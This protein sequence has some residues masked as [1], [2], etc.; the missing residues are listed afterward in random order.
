MENRKDFIF[1]SFQVLFAH[2]VFLV[3]ICEALWFCIRPVEGDF[4]FWQYCGS[5]VVTLVPLGSST[6][7]P[8]SANSDDSDNSAYPSPFTPGW[9]SF[10]VY[11]ESPFFFSFLS[12]LPEIYLTY[13]V[14]SVWG[15]QQ[16]FDVWTVHCEVIIR[17]WLTSVTLCSYKKVFFFLWLL[18][19]IL[20]ATLRYAV[21]YY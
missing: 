21:Q 1:L 15:V 10:F 13:S 4:L 11:L 12:F 8:F 7:P 2:P 20:S 14:L 19:S 17:S 3:T 5:L 16:W 9:F 6:P 18:R